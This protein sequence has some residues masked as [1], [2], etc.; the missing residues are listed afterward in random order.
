MAEQEVK[1]R[2]PSINFEAI[3]QK[4]RQMEDDEKFAISDSLQTFIDESS[5]QAGYQNQEKLDKAG[6]RQEVIN[7]V[8]N[9]TITNLDGLKGADYDEALQTQKSTDKQ[10]EEIFKL[11]EKQGGLNDAEKQ[12]IKDTV[13]A[14]N[15]KLGEILG[16]STRLKLAFRDFKK[17]LKPLK[18]AARVGLTNIPIIGKRIERAIRAEEEGEAEALRIK[19][20]LRK[21]EA[22]GARKAGD[23]DVAE[24]QTESE[25]QQTK[26]QAKQATAQILGTDNKREEV[27]ADKEQRVEEERESDT[28]FETTANI[29]ERILE[30]SELTNELLG[31]KGKKGAL[32]GDGDKDGFS[33]LEVLGL[34]K[35]ADFAKA[36]GV[37]RLITS[38][39]SLTRVAGIF[40]LAATAGIG[41]G[42]LIEAIGMRNVGE[43]EKKVINEQSRDITSSANNEGVLMEDIE[44]ESNA[45]LE[46]INKDEYKKLRNRGDLDEDITL[47][48]YSR[49]KKEARVGNKITSY[50]T[51]KI[52]EGK[53]E[54]IMA[55]LAGPTTTV[56]G[57]VTTNTDTSSITNNTTQKMD[58]VAT[59]NESGM[60]KSV[61]ETTS[62]TNNVVN[63]NVQQNDNSQ[64][65]NKTEYGSST[66]GTKNNSGFS[67]FY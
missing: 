42:K 61:N 50:F 63:N 35:L 29:L 51:G 1:F 5:K 33:I 15:K 21:R 36:G 7:F 22:R 59:M 39:K 11:K 6:I 47:E 67:D 57:D 30:E 53:L 40:G 2:K 37:T 58:N 13:Q 3:L 44:A 20:G 66:I 23:L 19:R 54:K 4:Q 16:L 8:D 34:K 55:V 62:T 46:G 41:L 24:T 9:Y 48:Q 32:A 49:A 64:N 27:F 25:T 28:Q 60:N 52:K 38:L 12:Y 31:G 26:T 18:L 17:E 14:T 10:I 45:R 65:T 56:E 43:E